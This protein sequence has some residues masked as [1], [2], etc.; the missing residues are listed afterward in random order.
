[1]VNA[2]VLSMT[3]SIQDA[4]IMSMKKKNNVNESSF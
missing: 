3:F 2:I 1:M 4:D